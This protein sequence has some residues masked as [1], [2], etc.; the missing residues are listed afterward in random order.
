MARL[1]WQSVELDQLADQ[2]FGALDVVR[3]EVVEVAVAQDGADMHRHGV[4]VPLVVA[5]VIF[6]TFL[7]CP[8]L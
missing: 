6:F 5:G 7:S 4:D 8:C 2:P 1:V 3:V